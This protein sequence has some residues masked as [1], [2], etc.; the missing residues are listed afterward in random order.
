M[1]T[2]LKGSLDLWVFLPCAQGLEDP[3]LPLNGEEE[4]PGEAAP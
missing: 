3:A 2:L 4:A 1:R